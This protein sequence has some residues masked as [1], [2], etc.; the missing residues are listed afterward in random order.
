M[1]DEN[2]QGSAP[3]G[4]ESQPAAPAPTPAQPSESQQ[5]FTPIP[6]KPLTKSDDPPGERRGG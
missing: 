2:T 5:L 4:G 3:A 1:T 6:S